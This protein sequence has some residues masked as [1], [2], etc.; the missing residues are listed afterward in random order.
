MDVSRKR[1]LVSLGMVAT[2]VAAVALAN[3]GSLPGVVVF[4]VV[5][6]WAYLR[7]AKPESGLTWTVIIATALA[8]SVA[9][10]LKFEDILD[11][12]IDF[13][14]LLVVQRFIHRITTRAHIQLGLLA[15]LLMMIAAV[16]NTSISYPLLLALFLPLLTLSLILNHFLG[17]AEQQGARAQFDSE[18]TLRKHWPRLIRTAMTVSLALAA[19][20]LGV[21]LF[22][23]F[24]SITH[25]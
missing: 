14:L 17:Q 22:F 15:A 10:I 5:S 2:S 25:Y 20:G 12:A 19:V 8:A 11:S 3:P 7:P 23:P 21:F 13:L 16:L 4:S 9:R 18:I 6:T 24:K 1:D